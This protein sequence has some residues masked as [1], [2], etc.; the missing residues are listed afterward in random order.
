VTH[1]DTSSNSSSPPDTTLQ[2][3]GATLRQ[4]RQHAGL[5]HR[6]LAA[7]TG[8]HYTYIT[9]IEQGRRNVSV[10]ALLR[11]ARALGIP[12]SWLLAQLDPRV[13]LAPSATCNPLPSR[14]DRE[15]AVPHDGPSFP[16]PDDM[17]T[18][19]PLLGVTIRQS[20]RHQRLTRKAL[21]TM[22]GLSPTYI[23]EIER[24]ERNVSVLSFVRIADALG[25]TVSHL[26]AALET[27]QNLSSP[28]TE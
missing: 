3:F 9:Q 1:R 18:L 8:I 17:A 6:A 20:R 10:L 2:R 22:T 19:L 4:Y 12:S 5:S 14:G 24:G 27:H 11:L 26:L 23:G 15:A 7:K 28:L 21:A 16:Q 25:L 13:P